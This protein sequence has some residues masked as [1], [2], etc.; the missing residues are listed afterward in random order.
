MQDRTC[1]YLFAGGG[2][3][4]H[5]YPAIA[6]AEEILRR[7][8]ESDIHFAGTK[9][10][11]ERKVIPEKGFALHLIAVRGMARYRSII[12]FLIPFRL[13]WSLLQSLTLLLRLH[14]R[15]V[16]GTGGY[17]SGP[18]LFM[19]SVLNYPTL[20][21]EQNSYPGITTRLLARRVDRVHLSFEISKTYFKKKENL[22]VTGNPVRQLDVSES[23]KEARQHFG[24]HGDRVTLFVFGGSQGASAI[25]QALLESLETLLDETDIQ[26]I[27]ST[28]PSEY[29]K[30]K[31]K[32][33]S[34]QTRLFLAPFITNMPM[35]YRAVDFALA[36]AGAMT[37]TE[38]TACGCPSVLI[39]Y[40]YAAANHQEENSRTLEKAGAAKMILQSNLTSQILIETV[41]ELTQDEDKRQQMSHVAI[42]FAFPQASQK[43]VDSLFEL[44]EKRGD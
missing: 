30:I 8:P 40:P 14:P 33:E 15:A 7:Q 27:W 44:C 16:I 4:G 34:W 25:N 23:K 5:I 24:L 35:A 20:I 22:F 39:P 18:V 31:Q 21:Q 38:L 2:T 11:L 26:I 3:G 17:V 13:L 9:K 29:E 10:G 36:R 19:A 1:T 41:K 12:N 6:I 37:L 32:T 42:K 43:I 28:G